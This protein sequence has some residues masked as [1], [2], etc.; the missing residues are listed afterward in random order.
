MD[1]S[2]LIELATG[3]VGQIL[4]TVI[5][6][7]IFVYWL[8]R[9]MN[10]VMFDN[11]TPQ[12]RKL[13]KRLS[14]H[15]LGPVTAVVLYGM[16]VLVTPRRGFWGYLGVA[17]LGWAGSIVAVAWHHRAKQKAAKKGKLPQ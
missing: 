10:E 5:V 14:S 17:F 3:P 12:Q 6:I 9:G 16:K 13:G 4:G 8:Q 11:W 7:G 2:F 1:L 15:L